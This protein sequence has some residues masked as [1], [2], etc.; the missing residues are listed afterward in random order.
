[1]KRIGSKLFA[2]FLSMSVLTVGLLWLI[3]AVIMKDNYL[4]ERLSAVRSAVQDAAQGDGIEYSDLE[5]SLAVSLIEVDESGGNIRYMSPNTPMRG[6]ILRQIQAFS[7]QYA[8]GGAEYL[9][10][11]SGDMHYAVLRFRLNRG[12]ALYAVFSLADVEEA[13]RILQKQ[14]W[15]VT[16]ALLFFSAVFALVLSRMFSR[17][18][19]EVT[20]AARRMAAGDLDVSLPVKSA[21]ETGQLTAALNELGAQL[22]K[23]EKLRQELIANVSHELKSPLSVI[24]GFAET[25]RDVTWLDEEKRSAQLTII[26]DEASRLSKIV[27]DILDFSRLQAG[28]DEPEVSF[29]PVCPVLSDTISRYEPEARGKNIRLALD[30]PELS[31]RFDSGRFAQ[32]MDNLLNNAINHAD[33]SSTISVTVQADKNAAVI[34]VR[35]FGDT[36]PQEEIPH[37]W[38]RYY[39]ASRL[40][41]IRPLGT[42]LGLSIVKSIFSKHGVAYGVKSENNQTVF[43]FNTLPVK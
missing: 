6:M 32:V 21:D 28:V 9:T 14:L 29:F 36:I 4:L 26:A 22:Q 37:I 38:D 41:G 13:S 16:A 3:Q 35:N 39:R 2:G 24:Q 11:S 27:N 43:W 31:V 25:V 30:C 19:K 5:E 12:G 1:M 42:G 20:H 34:A 33:P 8:S 23:T 15:I 10:V 18:I 40:S 7:K 17:P